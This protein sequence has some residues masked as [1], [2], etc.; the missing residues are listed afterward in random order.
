M[1]WLLLLSLLPVHSL[2]TPAEVPAAM[3]QKWSEL[4]AAVEKG[5]GEARARLDEA[6]RSEAGLE[7]RERAR[8]AGHSGLA[9]ALAGAAHRLWDVA[10]AKARSGV[11]R[12]DRELH[13]RVLGP[14]EAERATERKAE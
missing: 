11:A 5:Y 8:E 12:L 2:A 4:S 13:D 6:G 10:K 14:L 7:L 3:K 1:L 9:Q